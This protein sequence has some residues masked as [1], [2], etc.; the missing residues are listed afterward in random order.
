[1]DKIND[2]AGYPPFQ[3]IKDKIYKEIIKVRICL[4]IQNPI[5]FTTRKMQTK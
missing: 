4:H 5:K 2:F 1:M 3:K